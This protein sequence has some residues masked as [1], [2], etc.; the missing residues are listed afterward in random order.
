MLAGDTDDDIIQA[1]PFISKE[2][3]QTTREF[4]LSVLEKGVSSI[5]PVNIVA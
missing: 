3:L 4:S 2:Y 5:T 1:Y